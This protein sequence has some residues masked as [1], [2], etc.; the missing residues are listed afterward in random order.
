MSNN[1]MN[2][3]HNIKKRVLKCDTIILSDESTQTNINLYGNLLPFPPQ[4]Q[5][6]A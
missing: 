3:K 5:G 1:Y 6:H 2:K 4:G